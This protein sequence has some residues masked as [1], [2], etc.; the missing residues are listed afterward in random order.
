M[1][2]VNLLLMVLIQILFVTSSFSQELFINE[3]ITKTSKNISVN[4]KNGNTNT[5][6]YQYERQIIDDYLK[7]INPNFYTGNIKVIVGLTKKEH[8]RFEVFLQRYIS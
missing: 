8:Y 5:S 6:D 1:K 3:V 4:A 2:K 7:Q